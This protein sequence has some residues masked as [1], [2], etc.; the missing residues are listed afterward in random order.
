MKKLGTLLFA[1]VFACSAAFA[2]NASNSASQDIDGN[3]NTSTI[4][5]VK[6]FNSDASVKQEGV[7]NSSTITQDGYTQN[8]S[9]YNV[10]DENTI[11]Q[12]QY[13]GYHQ[14][15][16]ELWGNQNEYTVLQK[17]A[18]NFIYLNAR[19]TGPGLFG[20]PSNGS[21]NNNNT[22]DIRQ[23]GYRNLLSGSITGSD[24]E[25]S[26]EQAGDYNK[27]GGVLFEVP[28]L[29]LQGTQT[30]AFGFLQSLF[31]GN[32]W[33]GNGVNIYGDN[34]QASLKQVGRSNNNYAFIEGDNN[35]VT[36]RMTDGSDNTVLQ[37]MIGS[38]NKSVLE[39]WG[40]GNTMITGQM[41]T[42]NQLFLNSRG[43]GSG[44][45]NGGGNSSNLFVALQVND[46]NMIS[47]GIDGSYN[48]VGIAQYG[49]QN[50][51]GSGLYAADGVRIVGNYNDVLISQ[52]GYGNTADA[53]IT[54]NNNTSTIMQ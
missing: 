4:T 9:L 1:S 50:E 2:Q 36:Q 22:A 15:R 40:D 14:Q 26:V 27:I 8:A 53:A 12:S 51:I 34:N 25:V 24:N 23:D 48:E 7:D 43:T 32:A 28:T 41:G 44:F 20:R 17:G 29:S 33:S 16:V 10:G 54:G 46:D 6:A 19:G 45:S 3:A 11:S 5:Q 47:A 31:N 21:N 13:G 52:H 30:G 37:A 38:E 18:Q 49:S 35:Q 42:G 39:L